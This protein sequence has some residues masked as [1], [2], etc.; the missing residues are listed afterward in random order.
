MI[1]IQLRQDLFHDSFSEK[2]CLGTY[3]EL[4]TILTNCSHLAVIQIYHL[5]MTAYQRFLLLLQIFRI[6]TCMGYGFLLGHG[7]RIF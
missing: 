5:S 3:T 7:K 2:D 4:F 6:D 1:V